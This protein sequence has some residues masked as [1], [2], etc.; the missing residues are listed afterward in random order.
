MELFREL[1]DRLNSDNSLTMGFPESSKPI[2]SPS[3][4][5]R[6]QFFITTI[7]VRLLAFKT[8]MEKWR[9]VWE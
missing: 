1:P 6:L 3:F 7:V 2:F 5:D 8:T 4:V 9:E